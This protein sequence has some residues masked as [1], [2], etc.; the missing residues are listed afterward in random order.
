M[1]TNEK[2]EEKKDLIIGCIF[3]IIIIFA[4]YSFIKY[5]DNK[6]NTQKIILN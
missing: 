1:G 5:L 6:S 2:T 4:F 3:L